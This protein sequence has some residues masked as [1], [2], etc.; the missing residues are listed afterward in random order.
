MSQL[1]VQR[2]ADESLKVATEIKQ[3]PKKKNIAVVFFADGSHAY[4]SMLKHYDN[5][6]APMFLNSA[7]E[8]L[9]GWNITEMDGETWLFKAGNRTSNTLESLGL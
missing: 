2:V 6:G 7:N 4:T 9:P 3:S 8:V 5:D 1:K